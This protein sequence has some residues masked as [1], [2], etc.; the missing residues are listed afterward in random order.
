[1]AAVYVVAFFELDDA[2]DEDDEEEIGLV[3]SSLRM[4]FVL[5]LV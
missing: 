5:L 4:S 1:M 3:K 2:D